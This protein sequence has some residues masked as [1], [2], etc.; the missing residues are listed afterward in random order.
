MFERFGHRLRL[1]SKTCTPSGLAYLVN[2]SILCGVCRCEP[3]S[4]SRGEGL[5]H[6][7]ESPTEGGCGRAERPLEAAA[8]IELALAASSIGLIGSNAYLLSIVSDVG[9]WVGESGVVMEGGESF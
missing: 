2:L 7:L 9:G 4:E 6:G 1:P 5:P 3:G 8:I